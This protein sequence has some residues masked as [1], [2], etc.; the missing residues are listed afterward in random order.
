MQKVALSPG[1]AC[2]KI[3]G[4]GDLGDGVLAVFENTVALQ[5]SIPQ[6]ICKLDGCTPSIIGEKGIVPLGMEGFLIPS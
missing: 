4:G 2:G 3:A 5:V 1:R 6:T